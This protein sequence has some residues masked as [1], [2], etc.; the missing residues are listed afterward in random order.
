MS[1]LSEIDADSWKAPPELVSAIREAYRLIGAP[2]TV[3]QSDACVILR[4]VL[5]KL[6][7]SSTEK[8]S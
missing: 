5:E 3:Q 2:R 8:G 1:K 4:M 6:E 7:A